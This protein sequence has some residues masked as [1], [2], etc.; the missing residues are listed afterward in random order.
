MKIAII[1]AHNSILGFKALGLDTYSAIK[2]EEALS[3][4]KVILSEKKYAIVFI[5]ED[6]AR[7]I[8]QELEAISKVTMPA[9]ITVP[10]H[11][12]S[13]GIGLARLRKTVE[14]AV[15]SDILFRK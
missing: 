6:L 14:Q 7:E 1:G 2:G 13:F 15:G 11:K 4:L 12:G 8:K 9:I 3:L 10:S 5:T